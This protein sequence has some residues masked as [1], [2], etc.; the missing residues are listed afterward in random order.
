[1]VK[2]VIKGLPHS[3]TSLPSIEAGDQEVAAALTERE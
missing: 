1:M 2:V 3:D